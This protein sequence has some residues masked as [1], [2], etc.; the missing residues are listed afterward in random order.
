[1]IRDDFF[2]TVDFWHYNILNKILTIVDLKSGRWSVDV[3]NNIQLLAY[4]LMV[5]VE[6]GSLFKIDKYILKIFQGGEF[7]SVEVTPAQLDKARDRIIDI[8]DAVEEAQVKP[9][10]FLD[11]DCR[12]K[13]CRAYAIH[14]GK[15][16]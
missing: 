7:K 13:F 2:G 10:L 14:E 5:K 1:M 15:R 16:R 12:S 3:K 6:L 11:P 4:A 9:D 8:S